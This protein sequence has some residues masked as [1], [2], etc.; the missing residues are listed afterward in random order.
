MKYRSTRGGMAPQAFSDILLEGLAPDG[1]LA[2]PESLPQ[3]DA[4]TLAS[5]RGLSYA[6]LACE[7]LSRFA[8]D[9]PR[10]DLARLTKAAYNDQVFSSEDIVP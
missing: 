8:T 6:E 4:A 1:G 9:I 5:W 2:V 7:V 3:I 10:E